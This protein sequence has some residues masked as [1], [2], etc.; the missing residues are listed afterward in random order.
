MLPALILT[1]GIGARLDPL[2]RLVAKPAVP[3]AGQPLVERVIAWL[4]TQG[5]ADVVLNLH[6]RPETVAGVV[7]DGAHLGVRARYSWEQPLLGSGGGPRHALPLLDSDPFLIVNGDTLCDF[8]LAL[9]LDAHRLAGAGVTMAVVPNPAPDHYNGILLDDEDRIVGFVPKGPAASGSWHFVGVQIAHTEVFRPLVD[10]L[11]AET[12]AGLYRELIVE[13]PGWLRGFRATTTFID[14]GTPS[15]YRRACRSLGDGA[16]NIVWAGSTVA[17]D[18]DVDNCIVAGAVHVPSGV[19]ARDA[20]IVPAS[21][22]R[23]GDACTV[24]GEI[25][26]FAIGAPGV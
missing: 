12:V 25:A 24:H 17:P 13:R 7:G 14:V 2:T 15:D 10:G 23:G 22:A 18:A 20:V 4:V 8:D 21:I 16:S 11:A 5:V 1:A 19:H 9:M 26:I 3:I 6:H